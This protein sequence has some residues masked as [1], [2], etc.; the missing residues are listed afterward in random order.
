[1]NQNATKLI[2]EQWGRDKSKRVEK[3]AWLI[4]FPITSDLH[5]CF[6]PNKMRRIKREAQIQT[7]IAK[8]DI[9]DKST[10]N[11]TLT[12]FSVTIDRI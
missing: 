9:F 5:F 1:M 10:P 3:L 12:L 7:K 11:T 8:E 6:F 2:L 4:F